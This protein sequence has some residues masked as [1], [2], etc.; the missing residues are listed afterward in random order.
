MRYYLHMSQ[1]DVDYP[2][3]F[4]FSDDDYYTRIYK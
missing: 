4:M 3:W 1:A 2:K